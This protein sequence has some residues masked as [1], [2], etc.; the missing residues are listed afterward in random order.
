[1]SKDVPSTFAR[2]LERSLRGEFEADLHLRITFEIHMNFE[3]LNVTAYKKKDTQHCINTSGQLIPHP[4]CAF[5]LRPFK[6]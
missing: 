3:H 5:Q 1:M 2:S 4:F 6:V